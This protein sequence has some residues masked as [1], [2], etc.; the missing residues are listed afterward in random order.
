MAV[1]AGRKDVVNHCLEFAALH[2]FIP[3]SSKSWEQSHQAH[4][5]G[6]RVFS[7]KY[8]PSVAVVPVYQYR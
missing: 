8:N 5:E 7:F 1:A 2:K 4:K 3:N 6:N